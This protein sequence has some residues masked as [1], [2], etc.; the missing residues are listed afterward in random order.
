MR[1]AMIFVCMLM[2]VGLTAQ[3]VEFSGNCPAAIDLEQHQFGR[4]MNLKVLPDN[5]KLILFAGLLR[6]GGQNA[7]AQKGPWLSDLIFLSPDGKR[8]TER[9][10]PGLVYVDKLSPTTGGTGYYLVSKSRTGRRD[11]YSRQ[12]LVFDSKGNEVH[13]ISDLKGRAVIPA[14]AGDGIMIAD[15]DAGD[16]G[17]DFTLAQLNPPRGEKMDK[18]FSVKVDLHFMDNV[19][20]GFVYLGGADIDYIVSMGNSVWR[21]SGKSQAKHWKIQNVGDEITQISMSG[22]SFLRIDTPHQVIF[23]DIK[24]G[25]K[26]V[27]LD[28]HDP[29]WSQNN[30]YLYNLKLEGSKNG[31]ITLRNYGNRYHL[32]MKSSARGASYVAKVKKEKIHHGGSLPFRSGSYMSRKMGKEMGENKF[33]G[34]KIDGMQFILFSYEE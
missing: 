24:S 7:D 26:V 4:N 15:V 11:D 19:P 2:T 10:F 32:T 6:T 3:N 27:T 31:L 8:I 16:Y 22:S 12:L 14:V 13:A 1:L 20:S 23:A 28:R 17:R 25:R 21:E 34:L 30:I 9:Q 29:A 33:Y 18:A 5:S